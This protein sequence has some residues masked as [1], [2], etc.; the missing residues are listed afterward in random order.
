TEDGYFRTGDTGTIDPE[1]FLKI[2]DRLKDLIKSGGE[3]IS[4]VDMENSLVSYPKILEAAV[5][6]CPHPKWQE[7]PLALVVVRD[8]FK[9]K[10]T[11]EEIKKYLAKKFARWQLPEEILFVNRILKTGVGKIDK[12]TIRTEYKDIYT[13]K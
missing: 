3:W 9:T 8:E 7:R 5:V 2:T 6:G 12:K 10:V 1:G 11:K 4:S 13:S